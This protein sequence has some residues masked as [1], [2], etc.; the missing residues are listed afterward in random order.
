MAENS[1]D[2]VVLTFEL[3]P[4]EVRAGITGMNLRTFSFYAF[5]SITWILVVFVAGVI[6]ASGHAVNVGFIVAISLV[7]W[8]TFALGILW[9]SGRV[10]PNSPYAGV[11]T[12]TISDEGLSVH[13]ARVQSH[14]KWDAVR[15]S[16]E[17]REVYVL[18]RSVGKTYVIIPKRVLTEAGRDKEDTLRRIL[19]AQTN[20][21]PAKRRRPRSQTV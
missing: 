16:Y 19:H 6:A 5:S 3:R 10:T 11:R 7:S 9:A 21:P 14:D 15:A 13:T 18:R 12:V 8:A 20:L 1:G 2:A 17:L 4:E